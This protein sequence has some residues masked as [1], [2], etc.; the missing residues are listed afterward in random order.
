MKIKTLIITF[1]LL[2][3]AVF[4]NWLT[5]S[6]VQKKILAQAAPPQDQ[7]DSF[8]HDVVFLDFDQNG[9]MRNYLTSPEMNHYVVGDKYVLQKPELKISNQ[10]NEEWQ[11]KAPYGQSQNRNDSIDLWGGVEIKQIAGSKYPG[12]NITTNS[13]TFY[14]TP[15]YA[16]T[17]DPISIVQPGSTMQA[18][19]AKVDFKA[20]TLQLLSKVEERYVSTAKKQK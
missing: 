4:T 14:P 5:F 10:E 12:L 11:I 3:F 9:I 20:S 6:F 1:V 17:K 2:A 8:M 18:V 19:G 16:E 7:P 15:K 13:L